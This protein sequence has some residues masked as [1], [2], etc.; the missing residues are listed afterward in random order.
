M[1]LMDHRSG[2]LIDCIDSP[3]NTHDASMASQ[4]HRHLQPGD[5]LLGDDAFGDT[6]I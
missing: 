5:I 1:L 3:M 4:T 2:L 6:H